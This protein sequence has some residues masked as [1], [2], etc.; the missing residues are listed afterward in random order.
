MNP[1]RLIN[2]K[3]RSLAVKDAPATLKRT[4]DVIKIT[5]MTIVINC[6]DIIII[7]IIIIVIFHS[8]NNILPPRRL[9][10]GTPHLP[11]EASPEEPA[12]TE[13]DCG[14]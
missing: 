11:A 12:D 9:P 1:R 4:I 13:E 6:V 2:R 8:T 14:L 10:G 5:N 7:T 3:R